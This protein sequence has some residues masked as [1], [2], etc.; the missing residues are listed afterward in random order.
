MADGAE[1][2][3]GVGGGLFGHDGVEELGFGGVDPVAGGVGTGF[4]FGVG[5]KG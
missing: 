4:G 2:G 3:V 5:W 1:E